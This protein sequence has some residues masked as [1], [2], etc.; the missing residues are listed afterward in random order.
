M[1]E[2]AHGP[3]PGEQSAPGGAQSSERDHEDFYA[4][5]T[6][7]N[8]TLIPERWQARLRTTRFVVAGCGSTGGACV[9]PLL[10]SGAER[11][12]LLDPGTY[13][14]NNLNRQDATVAEIGSNKARATERR[15]H[16]VNPHADIVVYEDGVSAATIADRLKMGD[17]VIDA[18]DV[19]SD[20]G[21]RAK[22]ALHDAACKFRLK[23]LTA[24]DIA[25]TQFIELFDYSKIT[26]PLGGRV[27]EPATA[28]RV[29]R[30]LIPPRA[31]PR[32][33]FAELVERRRDPAR[34]FPQLAMTST[35]LGSLVVPYLLQVI[36][37]HS[38]KRR[39]RVDLYDLTRTPGA[40]WGARL[41]R[42]LSL[43]ALWWRLR[44]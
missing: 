35:L 20:Q 33:I 24:Y 28:D 4:A 13:E 7:R 1:A 27:R 18:V 25:T 37:G 10:R 39:L 32:D 23:V 34:G 21:V 11:L 29:L 5:L 26:E 17:V 8:G 2:A 14:L 40:R 22:L 31:L 42:D 16:A 38:V 15:A 30:A 36:D 19:T 9:M 6:E 12:V 3:R 44:D 43:I 41:R